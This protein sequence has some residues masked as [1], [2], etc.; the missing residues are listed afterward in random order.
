MIFVTLGTQKQ[1]FKRLLQY[2]EESNI[3]EEIIVQNGNTKFETKKMKLIGFVSYDEMDNYLKEAS[4]VISHGGISVIDALKH[5]KKVI[6]CPRDKKY[7][8]HINNHQYEMNEFLSKSKY[9]L[10]CTTKE[11]FN[12]CINKIDK[13]SPKKWNNNKILLIKTLDK[14]IN[15]YLK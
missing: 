15:D 8:E 5:N 6:S 10:S 4:Y 3:N 14:T 11:E 2:I 7:K 9:L 1:Q 13:F 12:K